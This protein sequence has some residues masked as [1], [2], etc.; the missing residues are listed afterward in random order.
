MSHWFSYGITI[1]KVPE[2]HDCD[3]K[4]SLSPI[5][6]AWKLVEGGACILAWVVATTCYIILQLFCNSHK[7]SYYSHNSVPI[8]LN[9]SQE[10]NIHILAH[11]NS[12]LGFLFLKIEDGFGQ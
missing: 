10:T 4:P 11:S 2:T 12:I 5:W 7:I 9:Y 8:I 1:A 6:I 3:L